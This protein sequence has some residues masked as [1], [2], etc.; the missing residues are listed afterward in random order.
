M[1]TQSSW[2]PADVDVERASPARVYDYLLGGAWNFDSDREMAAQAIKRMPWVRDLARYNRQFL[3][4]AVRHLAQSGV[5]QFLDLGSGMP[6]SKSVHEMA[7]ETHADA[8]VVYVEQE[9]VAVAHSELILSS[10]PGA[11][12]VGMDMCAVAE[13]LAHPVTRSL[14]DLTEPVGVVLASSLHYVLDADEAARVV[15]GYLAAV[16]PGS[17]LVLSHITEDEGDGSEEVRRLVELSRSTTAA[18]VARS[19]AW[20]ETLFEGLDVLAPGLVYTSQW[21]PN[22][23]LRLVTDLPAHASLLA[24]VARKP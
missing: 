6:T 16:P 5:R 20:I 9:Q 14:L 24:A 17:H 2:V 21:R 8:R 7:A 4:R 19:R 1:S 22:S 3:G 10:V 15:R 23:P 11:G 18:G 12:V 13:V